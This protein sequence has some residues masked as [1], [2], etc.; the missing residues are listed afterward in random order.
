MAIA[1]LPKKDEDLLDI[2]SIEPGAQDITIEGEEYVEVQ[3][4]A[5]KG[6][7]GDALKFFGSIWF[8]GGVMVVMFLAA[9]VLFGLDLQQATR[10][11]KYI[12]Q[13][14]QLLMLSQRLAKDAREAVFGQEGA[15]PNLKNSRETFEGIT[16]TLQKGDDK[17]DL[18]PSPPE[19]TPTLAELAKIWAQ[20]RD[21]TDQILSQQAT[22]LAMRD[23]VVAINQV[24]PLLLALSDEVVELGSTSGVKPD[25]LYLAGRQ[26]MLSQRISKD[27]N[28]FAQGGAEAAVAAAQFGKDSKLFKETNAVLA[29]SMPAA[30]RPKL[31]EASTVFTEMDKHISGIL[32]NAAELFV[33]QRAS[34][35]VF[36]QSDPLLESSRKLVQGYTALA[37]Q[38]ES[39][40]PL[41]YLLSGIGIVFMLFFGNKLL[42]DEKQRAQVSA[43]K[44][45]QTEDAILKLLD[46]MGNLADGDLTIQPEVTE[47]ITGAIADSIN[48]AVKEMRSLVVGIKSAAQQVAVASERTRQTANELTQA[49]TR[50]AAQIT[51]TTDKM[52]AMARSMEDMSMSAERSAQVAQGSLATAKRGTAAV[53]DTIRGMDQMR[54]QIQETAKRIKR[55]GESSQQI[56]EIVELINDIAE[57]T[58]ILSLNAAIQAAMAGEAGRGFAVVADE[59][60]RLAERSGEATKQI[61]D[62]VKTIQ[63]DTNEAVASME[64]ATRGVVEG[65]R[66]ADAAGQALGEIESVSEQLS[67]LIVDIAR[68]AHQ[69]SELATAMSGNMGQ[70]Q[71]ATT[72]TSTGTRQ[73]AESIG[74]LSELARELQASVAGFKL[75]A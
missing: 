2:S 28:L 62:L 61:S 73:T 54:E 29:K 12:E 41:S 47:Q 32:G 6:G 42:R 1:K 14:S 37:N 35:L 27:V 31:E 65:T 20:V 75:P 17:I 25:L 24:S 22:M 38:R 34:Q 30:M 74:R 52:K 13:S 69:Q 67:T 5:A 48:F 49:T 66:L 59:V 26:G 56:G 16:N 21:N 63:A 68:V 23:H 44:N 72:L 18:P 11:A 39:G 9:G 55:L 60:Q 19:V 71:E 7:G 53:H 50:Q 43:E 57:Q 10:D 3:A 4:P 33:S 58:N 45:R 70:I 15:F 51:E 46:E 64:H 40:V 8:I 36:E